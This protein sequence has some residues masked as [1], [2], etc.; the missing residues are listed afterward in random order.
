MPLTVLQGCTRVGPGLAKG[1][2][3]ITAI[4]PRSAKRF[5]TF[6]AIRA[7]YSGVLTGCDLKLDDFRVGIKFGGSGLSGCL[8]QS[9]AGGV[10]W[11]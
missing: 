3:R 8:E 9:M 5:A 1:L 7:R 4:G 11:G 10:E 6:A 2:A